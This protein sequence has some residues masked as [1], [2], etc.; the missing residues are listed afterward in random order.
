MMGTQNRRS[1]WGT[2]A[3]TLVGLVG[4]LGSALASEWEPDLD[5]EPHRY[6]QRTAVD[7]FSRRIPELAAGG[8]PL[9]RSSERAFLKSLLRALDI[10]E[11]SQ[12][13]VF[14]NTSLQLSLI[15]P[16]NPRAL[17][18]SDDLYLGYVPGGKIE[19]ATLDAELGAVFYIFDIPRSDSR[20]VVERARRCMNCH[21]N[22][23]TLKVPG[24]SVKSVAPGPGGGSLDTFHPG[25]SGH[26][27]PLAERFG[28]WYVT[29]TGGF[30]GHW[31]N[32]MGRLY[33]GEL[34]AT[35]LEPG[36]RFSFERYPVA[37]SDLLAHL[38]HEHQ[39]GGVNRLI[40]AQY[41]FRELR[42]RNGGSVPQALPPDLETELADLLSYLLFAQEAPLPASGIP[43][44]P[45]LRE[46]FAR[47]RKVVDGHSLKDL[48]LRTRLLRFRCSYLVHTPFFEGL[49]ADLRRRILRDL[50]HAL[51]PEKRNAA[52]RHLSDSEAAVIRTILRATVPGFPNGTVG[53]V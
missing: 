16:D 19:V 5:S 33:Q 8:L 45:A 14:S 38:L 49:D 52:S 36:T 20:V 21:A 43:G 40:R 41:R 48:D 31:G 35:P 29:G 46:G 10:P 32:R 30:D 11:S 12:L 47:N 1:P 34:S 51:S 23:D 4:V 27:Q 44:N 15:N 39:V 2:A 6:F 25:Q 7:R 13:L 26:T 42:H 53:P 22:E 3:R 17:Y 28:G 50:D 24:L 37:T 9:D 18:F